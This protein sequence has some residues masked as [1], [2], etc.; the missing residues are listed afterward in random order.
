MEN[1]NKNSAK[2]NKRKTSKQ[3]KQKIEKIFSII[4]WLILGLCFIFLILFNR[5][6][7]FSYEKNVFSTIIFIFLEVDLISWFIRIILITKNKKQR[8]L[9]FFA[10]I[11]NAILLMVCYFISKAD[12]SNLILFLYNAIF[13][14]YY[15]I[16][17][18]LYKTKFK[19]GKMYNNALIAPSLFAFVFAL[20][21][22]FYHTYIKTN[23]LYLYA[24]I[25]MS[26]ILVI[27]AILSFTI[28]KETYKKFFKSVIA[29]IGV[30]L[31]V[32]ICAYGFGLVFI[33]STNCAIKNKIT[34]LECS[35]V[36][37]NFS[38]TARGMST[39]ELYILINNKEYIIN[40]SSNLY[41]NKSVND[42]LK[43]NLFCGCFNLEYYEC[44]EGY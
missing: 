35:I 34:Q 6:E 29:K 17:F 30:L 13:I 12:I 44:G 1:N 27:F 19:T 36:R 43:V 21:K 39:Y 8:I 14:G 4:Q 15:V 5:S 31:M 3:K 25:P 22:T 40:V 26:I 32:L 41:Y 20:T 37:K 23:N 33:D 16:D 38:N 11:I 42:T 7:P 2:E 28:F 9:A 10:F 24:L 18:T